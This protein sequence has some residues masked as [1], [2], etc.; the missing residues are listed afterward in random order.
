MSGYIGSDG[1]EFIGAKNLQGNVQGLNVDVLGNLLVSAGAINPTT[2]AGA[3]VFYATTGQM[4][5]ANATVD[6][7]MSIFNPSNSGKNIL[8]TSIIASSGTGALI[9]FLYFVTTNPAYANNLLI[10]NAK[11]GGATSAI[12]G[13][14]VCTFVNTNQSAPGGGT[15]FRRVYNQFNQELIPNGTGILLPNGS[16]NGV[17]AMME[18]Y[19][20]GIG[21]LSA[22][23]VEF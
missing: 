21:A 16:A 22:Q 23:W 15:Q 2:L 10:S 18:T 12:G 5:S 11:A 19:A 20:T 8:I 6:A 3:Q 14:G 17:V 1:S 13:A 4:A 7:P 9:G